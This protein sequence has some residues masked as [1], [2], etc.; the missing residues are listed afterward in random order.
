MLCPSTRVQHENTVLNVNNS[1]QLMYIIVHCL[2]WFFLSNK[3]ISYLILSYL[4]SL[5]P[6]PFPPSP[7]LP[8]LPF[9]SLPLPPLP[10]PPPLPSHRFPSPHLR[11]LPLSP[12]L[13]P[14]PFPCHLF[15]SP[16]T[17]SLPLPPLPF[18]CHL[19]PSPSPPLPPLPFP[20]PCHLFPSPLPCHL[21]PSPLPCHLFPSPLP[22]H[23]FPSPSFTNSCAKQ[24]L[25]F[26]NRFQ[27]K[28]KC[29]IEMIW[30]CRR[31]LFCLIMCNLIRENWLIN[32]WAI[33]LFKSFST[34]LLR[35]SALYITG[36]MSKLMKYS[37][38]T[39]KTI[40]LADDLI[41]IIFWSGLNNLILLSSPRYA[42]NPSNNWN[43][44][45]R[46]GN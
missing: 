35:Y 30:R 12:P 25:E 43:R 41:L 6:L 32:D 24:I 13:P 27:K 40:L 42:F 29:Q 2:Y 10:F 1:L 15:P 26:M 3:W 9:P 44:K 31:V 39:G 5:P 23:L 14:L 8:P 20:L 7:P 34:K 21:F 4:P 37:R 19:F 18:P 46:H 45:G 28:I 11:P 38:L 17:S 33:Q 16:A 22:C 36:T